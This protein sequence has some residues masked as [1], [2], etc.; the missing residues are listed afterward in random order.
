MEIRLGSGVWVELGLQFEL[1]MAFMWCDAKK[2]LSKK[3]WYWYWQYFSTVVLVLVS[4]IL[5]AKVLVLVVAILF[6]TLAVGHV[7]LCMPMDD[8]LTKC[9]IMSAYY[10]CVVYA[11]SLLHQGHQQ[12][13]LSWYKSQQHS[14]LI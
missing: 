2:V 11:S 6:T 12:Q 8:K 14:N 13:T 3:Y 4:A 9:D 7:V 1:L 10:L 5:F